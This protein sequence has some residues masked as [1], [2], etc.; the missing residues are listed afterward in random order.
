MKKSS[1]FLI[2]IF[3]S[4][5]VLFSSFTSVDNSNLNPPNE[6][7]TLV[8]YLE[9]NGN[10]INGELP[11]MMADE[12][13]KNLKNPK[14]HIIDIRNDSWFEYGHIKGAANVQSADLLTYFGN[15]I[16]PSEFEKI[17]L[18]CYSGQSAAYYSSLLRIAGYNNVYSMKW[19]MSSWR[20][21]FAENSWLKN[22]KNDFA[23][24]LETTENKKPEKGA[25]P[26]LDTG[27]NE[28]KEILMTRL[29]T[30]FA[31]P[32][33]DFIVKSPEV[34]E[35]PSNYFIVNYLDQEN[36]NSGHIPQAVHYTPNNSLSIT[37]DL[38]T[39]PTDKKVVVY[40]ST[41]QKAAYV[42]AYLNVLGY[43]TGNLSYGENGFMNSVLKEKGWDAFTKKEINM[44]PV[45]E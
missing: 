33:R 32:Y 27:Q 28:A 45:I 4:A 8:N 14:Y 20:Q 42:I 7:E 43:Q 5:A 15:T 10:F 23:D 31:T 2:A 16:T 11:I 39:L 24:Q 41:G 18:V 17:I 36:Y 29:E 3:A 35:N 1:I 9:A 22:V 6:F 25:H 30:L 19:G 34:F 44:F 21:D 13:K 12:V 26:T 38:L 40:D 37:T